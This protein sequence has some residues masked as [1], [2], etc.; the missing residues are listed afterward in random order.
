MTRETD[1]DAGL[2][3]LFADARGDAPGEGLMARVLA[4]ASAV[5]A[6][7]A[8]VTP[9]APARRG[10][11]AGLVESFGGWGALSG[12]TAA[13]VMGLAIG[14]YAPTSVAD[15][16]GAETLGIAASTDF[17]PDMSALFGEDGDV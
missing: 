11:F 1:D 8:V 5:Q 15:W 4:D 3:A 9:V 6:E 10:W 7:A 16:F 2:E 13:G 14:L 17:A 12:A